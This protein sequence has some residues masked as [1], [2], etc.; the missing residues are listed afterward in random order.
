MALLHWACDRG[1][2]QM[3]TLLLESQADINI[4]DADGQTSLH[5][6]KGQTIRLWWGES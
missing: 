5:Y 3:V 4:Q 1:L 6:G 2:E